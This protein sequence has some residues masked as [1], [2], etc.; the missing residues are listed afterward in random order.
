M[1]DM[2]YLLQKDRKDAAAIALGGKRG[3]TIK[4]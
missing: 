2:S 4:K 3:R 1:K